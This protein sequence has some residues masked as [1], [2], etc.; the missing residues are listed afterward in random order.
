MER[1]IRYHVIFPQVDSTNR[2]WHSPFLARLFDW[3]RAPDTASLETTLN[4]TTA[5]T[6]L[7][8]G[9]MATDCGDKG[10]IFQRRAD[11]PNSSP[12]TSRHDE[13]YALAHAMRVRKGEKHPPPSVPS[14]IFLE[15][16]L[17]PYIINLHLRIG[18]LAV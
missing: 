17:S 18:S 6:G 10:W 2:N 16:T 12:P 13:K 5:T 11:V 4:R 14:D 7:T 8:I 15:L 1:S 9:T 3:I